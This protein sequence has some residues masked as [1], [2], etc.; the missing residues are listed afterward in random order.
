MLRCFIFKFDLNVKYRSYFS[1]KNYGLQKK[2]LV[3]K[4]CFF[5]SRL[6][7]N[8]WI[9]C[10]THITSHLIEVDEITGVMI[11]IKKSIKAKI[12]LKSVFL[13][14]LYITFH[15]LPLCVFISIQNIDRSTPLK[16]LKSFDF[17]IF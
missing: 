16:T 6:Y 2:L 17:T 12:F 7:K 3:E 5:S 10:C 11:S 13:N 8:Y 14:K 4:N 1:N 9:T 15:F